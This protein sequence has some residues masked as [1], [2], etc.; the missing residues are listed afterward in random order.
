MIGTL[1]A[2]E[3]DRVLDRQRVGRLAVSV[4]DRPYVVPFTYAYDGGCVYGYGTIGR[5]IQTMRVQP[6]VCFE[7]DEI[8]GPTSW[9]S[10]V[11]EGVYEE[12]TTDSERR[13]A[14]RHLAAVAD[15]FVPVE[16]NGAWPRHIVLFRLRL[17]NKSGRFERRDT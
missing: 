15:E 3:I 6:R 17:T 2:A 9:R 16:P 8:E 1:S 13:A 14:I 12:L 5:K 4:A 10:V 7:V 11:A